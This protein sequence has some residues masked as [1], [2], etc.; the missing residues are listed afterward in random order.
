VCDDPEYPCPN[1]AIGDSSICVIRKHTKDPIYACQFGEGE[2][3][4]FTVA[5]KIDRYPGEQ[6]AMAAIRVF[7][8]ENFICLHIPPESKV[9]TIIGGQPYDDA[10]SPCGRRESRISLATP[11]RAKKESDHGRTV[12][13]SNVRAVDEMLQMVEDDNRT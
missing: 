6:A 7:R 10:K 3:D 4:G 8:Y 2:K 1:T 5:D 12:N 11:E 13:G 9:W